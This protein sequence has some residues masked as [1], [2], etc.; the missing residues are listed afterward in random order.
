M[1]IAHL[2]SVHPQNDN[3]IFY[4]E[5][6]TLFQ[7]GYEITLVVAGGENKSVNGIE[8]IGYPK[9]KDR[10][11]KRILK[12]SFIDIIKVCKDID[13]NIYHF[14]DPEL[15]FVGL[16]LKLKGK[17]VIYDIHENNPASILSKPYIKSKFLKLLLSKT[18]NVF[19]QLSSR[20]FDA[21]V[22][23]RPDIT[24]RFK[25]KNIITL[26]NFPILP[27][28]SIIDQIKINKNKPSVIYVGGMTMQRGINELI[29][30]FEYLDEY[31][32]W[33]L[34][35]IKEEELKIRIESGCKNVRYFG[36]VEAYEIFNYINNADI[37]IITFLKEPNHVQTLATKPFEYMACGKPM[38]MSDFT[39][40]QDTFK[41]GSLYVDPS[42]PTDIAL[43]IKTLLND[44]Y[45]MNK[46]K[47]LNTQLSKYEYNWEKES[48]KLLTLY[49]ELEL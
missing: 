21:L 39:Y 35:N 1:K 22:T 18:F 16:Y 3:R 29:D 32:L 9:S 20:F 26:R 27:S 34:G 40:W 19:E 42:D 47:I 33:L 2:T 37:G 28:F 13:A 36:V 6:T 45:L 4:K 43:K 17:K 48:Q 38:I 10:R 31:E 46:M 5:C 41:G 8:I 23:A 14:H 49:R 30:A 12:T 25:H 44:E 24:K 15:M 7:N 11:V